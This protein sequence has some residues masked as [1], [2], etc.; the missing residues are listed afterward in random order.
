MGN[1]RCTQHSTANCR[2]WAQGRAALALSAIAVLST[3]VAACGGAGDP[4]PVR[5]V[6]SASNIS[7]AAVHDPHGYLK[8][9]GDDDPDDRGATKSRDDE[10][11]MIG[12][13]SQKSSP[14]D[15]KAV[16]IVV[17]RYFAAA[18]AED[19]ARGC[20]MLERSLA[21]AIAGEAPQGKPSCATALT[22]LFRVQHR[23]VSAE[24][25]ATMI[26]TGVHVEGNEALTTLGFRRTPEGEVILKREGGHWKL[27]A[28]FDSELP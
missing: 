7:S 3:V 24:E 25:P 15:L 11:E 22:H 21:A 27:D 12:R 9:D 5:T 26:I 1:G 16:S 20:A 10:Q 8:S 4:H 18:L 23:Y 2:S 17:K 28:L 19:G 6:T 14:A 13:S